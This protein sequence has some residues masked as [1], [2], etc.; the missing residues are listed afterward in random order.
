MAQGKFS[1]RSSTVTELLD[2]VKFIINRNFDYVAV[3]GEISNFSRSSQGHYYLSLS[4]KKSLISSVI[5]RGDSMRIPGVE[6]LKDGDVVEVVAELNLYERRG[7]V[8]LVIKKLSLVGEGDLKAQFEELKKK[9][10][11]EGLFE[12]SRK[13]IVPKYP[14]KIAVISAERSAAL[15]DFINIHNRRSVSCDLLIVPGIMQGD[16]SSISVLNGLKKILR[17]QDIRAEK[18]DCV[19][20]CRGGGSFEDLNSFNDEILARFVSEYPIPVISAIG[21]QTDYTILDFV[22]DIR[23]ET[24]SAAAEILSQHEFQLKQKLAHLKVSL[25]NKM[26]K[27]SIDVS[28]RLNFVKPINLQNILFRKIKK[29]SNFLDSITLFN[30]P[31]V[32]LGVYSYRQRMDEIQYKLKNVIQK[33]V[34]SRK[35]RLQRGHD[36][37]NALDPNQVMVRGYAI[38]KDESGHVISSSQTL[39][40]NLKIKIIQNDG[41]SYA[42]IL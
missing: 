28:R 24:P 11:N 19:V 6:K 10:Y 21:H 12:A 17:F 20:I 22:S 29:Y 18:I 4:D 38:L 31:E 2:Q 16:G 14:R 41:E 36:L 40:S 9:L 26:N 8:Q 15:E 27:F 13:K 42:K 5:F 34:T 7:Q 37:L 3:K 35:T 1:N 32:T 25:E 39:K 23:A 30:R 33:D